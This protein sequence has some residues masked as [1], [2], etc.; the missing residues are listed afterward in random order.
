MND[1]DPVLY[2][3]SKGYQ[4]KSSHCSKVDASRRNLNTGSSEWAQKF[5]G[6]NTLKKIS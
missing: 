3:P 5:S 4:R 2:S 1:T 6:K